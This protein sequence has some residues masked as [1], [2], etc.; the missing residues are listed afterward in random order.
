[1][2]SNCKENIITGDICDTVSA[3]PS[4][5]YKYLRHYT[6]TWLPIS[7]GAV[8]LLEHFQDVPTS[9]SLYVERGNDCLRT[10]CFDVFLAVPR[11]LS[12]S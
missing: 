8:V 6:D 11:G 7:F 5:S 2:Y 3:S 9:E 12:M 10:V 4:C 1:M